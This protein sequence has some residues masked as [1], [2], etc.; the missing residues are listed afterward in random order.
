MKNHNLRGEPDWEEQKLQ[1]DDF[2]WR[3][4][5]YVEFSQDENVVPVNNIMIGTILLIIINVIVFLQCQSIDGY[6]AMGGVNYRDVIQGGE[7][8]R[9]LSYM[10]L[11]IDLEHLCFNMIALFLFGKT[12]EEEFGSFITFMIYFISG[13][14]S[15]IC[16]VFM[17]HILMPDQWS[18]SIGASGAIYAFVISHLL[19][20]GKRVGSSRV[21]SI[22]IIV[23]YLVVEIAQTKS[24]AVDIFAHLGGAF[25]SLIMTLIIFGIQKERKQ[26]PIGLKAAGILLTVFFSLLAV[27]G[28][29]LGEVPAWNAERIQFIQEMHLDH[30]PEISYGEALEDFCSETAWKAFPSK[31]HREIVEFNGQC[32][33]QNEVT[34]VKIQ[35]ALNMDDSSC[36]ISYLS[37]N[38]ESMATDGIVDFFG[39]AFTDY[40]KNHGIMVEW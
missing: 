13:I 20:L 14:G 7:Y 36:S 4:P 30:L 37:L 34:K 1:Y 27:E 33:Y 35:F 26:E 29:R 11:H 17:H 2:D 38:G 19:I 40:G 12:V 16:S 21:E 25:I 15:G 28:A 5:I 24:V 8:R 18:N 23:I 32:F 6:A 31:K 10:F 9:L 39:K 3:E 22:F